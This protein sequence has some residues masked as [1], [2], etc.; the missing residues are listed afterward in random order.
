[1]ALSRALGVTVGILDAG[2]SDIGYLQHPS[3][4][5]PPMFWLLHLPGHYE[6]VYPREGLN[7]R[8]LL[9]G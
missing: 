7:V 4:V 2:G 6:V 5:A 9:A 1:M 3:G 8:L